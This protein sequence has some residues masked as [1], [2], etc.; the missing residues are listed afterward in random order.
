MAD[1]VKVAVIGVGHLGRIHA[2]LYA[3][4]PEVQ[5]AGVVDVNAAQAERV[6]RELRVP[7]FT[8]YQPLLRQVQAV[9]VAVPTQH[10]FAVA[11]HCLSNGIAVLVE[12]PMTTT[13]E[14]AQQLVDLSRRHGAILQVGHVERFNPAVVAVKKF[15]S[16]PR[17]IEADRIG[18]FSF[19]STDIGVVLDMMIHDLDI[20]LDLVPSE[21]ESVEAIGFSVLTT[22]EDIANARL[23]FRDG[24]VANLTASRVSPKTL[25]KI[26][27]FQRDAYISLDYEARKAQVYRRAPGV[28]AGSVPLRPT[29]PATADRLKKSLF[30]K[31]LNITDVKIDE[32]EPLR[33][34]L[35][36]F[37]QS[38]RDGSEPVVTG[39]MGMR[40]IAV[41][42]RILDE[43][44]AHQRELER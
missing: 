34:E 20:V 38:V 40:A 39:E 17:Y 22:K 27:L 21:V 12:K 33:M 6:G 28:E 30:T 36:A 5:L 2:S 31:Y 7:S 32:R 1:S 43:I 29:D 10:H 37:V 44:A 26:R 8:S 19:R 23:S 15:L 4:M 25:R 14:E 18:P 9:S 24:C 35:A 11:S 16:R 41:A 3:S 13:L 42:M